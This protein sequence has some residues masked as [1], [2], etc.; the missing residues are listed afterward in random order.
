MYAVPCKGDGESLMSRM[1]YLDERS[2]GVGILPRVLPPPPSHAVKFG[3]VAPQLLAAWRDATEC[4]VLLDLSYGPVAW[5]ALEACGWQPGGDASREVLYINT[6]GHEGLEGQMRRYARAG[7]LRKWEQGR[8]RLW[9]L[10]QWEPEE[11]IS[12]ARRVAATAVGLVHT[13]DAGL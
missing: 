13:R 4:G 5:A 9:Y 8:R 1:Q 7:H 2:R 11:V 3:T 6:G 10:G 12:E